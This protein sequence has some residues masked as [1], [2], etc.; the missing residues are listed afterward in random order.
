MLAI[1]PAFAAWAVVPFDMTMVLADVD[2]GL[3]YIL[4]MTSVPYMAS[5]LPVGPPILSMLS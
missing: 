5:L 1:A 2:A 4:A 3:L